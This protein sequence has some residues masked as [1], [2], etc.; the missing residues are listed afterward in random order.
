M[1]IP[2][3]QVDA[4]T[5]RLFGGNPA[6]VCPLEEWLPDEVMQK[7]AMEN[8]LSETAF[9]I[10]KEEGY[11]IRWF[12]PKV[13]V[14]L[15][16]HATLAS[17]HI[18]FQTTGI[19]DDTI[20][21]QSRS[22]LLNVRK[23]GDLLVLDF[24]ANK[25]QRTG[26]P[27]DF[28]HSLNI[29]PIQC[30]RGKEDYLLLYKTQQEIEALLPDFK[31]LEK[32]DARAVIVTAPGNHVDFVSRFFA[33]RVGVDEDPVTGSAHTVLIPFWAEKL[34]KNEMKALQLSRRGGSIFCRLRDDRVDI[35][36]KAVTYL[37][38]EITI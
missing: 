14:N 32:T 10:R 34:G 37:K 13:E 26:L 25:P 18:I 12:T 27:E 16:G 19:S 36:G 33:P 28:I 24:P 15:C 7:I 38:G 23:E 22:G 5:D 4:F 3:Y 30:H 1:N 29:T 31:R 6:G 9:Y 11:H 8:N 20:P 35:G 21:F 17:A 2:F